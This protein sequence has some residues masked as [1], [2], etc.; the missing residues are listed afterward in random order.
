[1]EPIVIVEPENEPIDFNSLMG[2][3]HDN[4]GEESALAGIYITAARKK[5]ELLTQRK[6]IRQKCRQYFSYWWNPMILSVAPV[7]EVTGM[8]YYDADGE[9]A[10]LD[11]EDYF[12]DIV[13]EPYKVHIYN[14]PSLA[15]NKGERRIWVE[16]WAGYETAHEVDELAV[17]MLSQHNWDNR[18]ATTDTTVVEI[19]FGFE[20]IVNLRKYCVWGYPV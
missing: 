9:E 14:K 6:V 11:Y 13:G 3:I 19:P 5:Y 16:Y 1:M 7:V 18:S 4:V 15:T 10:V 12:A 20:N 2:Q 17:R 8:F